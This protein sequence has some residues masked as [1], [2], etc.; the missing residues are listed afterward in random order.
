MTDDKKVNESEAVDNKPDEPKKP[1]RENTGET[2]TFQIN[3]VKIQSSH[4]KLVALDI[5][6]LAKDKGAIPGKPGD[7]ILQGKE[8]QYKSD[9]W[10]NLDE[11]NEFISI[12]I[13]ST[14]VA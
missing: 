9:D 12:P 1:D 3:G 6:K 2:H 5:L 13:T 8:T 11:D 14:H 7:Y 4:E 10:V